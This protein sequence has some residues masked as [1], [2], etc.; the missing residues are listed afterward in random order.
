MARVALTDVTKVFPGGTVA[1]DALTLDVADG[2]FMAIPVE[3]GPVE[4]SP[5]EAGPVSDV[6]ELVATG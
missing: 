2:E 6:A 4:A 3:P 1:V 5:V